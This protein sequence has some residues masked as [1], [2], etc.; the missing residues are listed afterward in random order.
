MR[1]GHDYERAEQGASVGLPVSVMLLS[2]LTIL[3]YLIVGS[4][5]LDNP[6]RLATT[7]APQPAEITPV[8]DE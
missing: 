8:A 5:F 1:D 2:L 6:N 3:V 4:A 7:Y